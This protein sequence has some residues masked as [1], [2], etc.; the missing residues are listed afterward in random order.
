VIFFW[1][2]TGCIFVSVP[3]YLFYDPLTLWPSLYA[4][5]I[6]AAVYLVTLLVYF[7]RKRPGKIVSGLAAGIVILLLVT[8]VLSWRTM[9]AMTAW[10]RA[11]L[12]LIRTV[13]SD[14][15]L[16]SD[17]VC[18]RSVSVFAAYHSQRG[19]KKNIVP[20]FAETYAGKIKDGFFP[21]AYAEHDP[22]KR[23]VRYQGDSAVVLIS[24]D[25]V[26]FGIRPDYRNINGSTGRLQLTTTLTA[27]GVRYERNN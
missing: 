14:D 24:V 19:T 12:G 1:L 25:T 2:L 21:S 9:D 3:F 15:I 23:Y 16:M 10:Q 27:S 20:L 6:A 5:G 17:D 26:A 8:S 22:T 18:D 13:I 11:Q 7:L 4:S